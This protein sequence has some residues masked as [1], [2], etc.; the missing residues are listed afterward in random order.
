MIIYVI[1]LV[2]YG[3]DR[4][5]ENLEATT[6]ASV[7]ERIAEEQSIEHQTIASSGTYHLP[8]V[9][10]KEESWNYDKGDNDHIYIESWYK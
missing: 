4:R 9:R 3:Y 7:A 8:I 10:T 5:Q 6:S 2:T 1:V